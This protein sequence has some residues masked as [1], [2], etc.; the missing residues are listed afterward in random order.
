LKGLPLGKL[1]MCSYSKKALR[2]LQPLIKNTKHS[3]KNF[4]SLFAP[5]DSY[6]IDGSKH[7]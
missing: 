3:I 4:M 6:T 5:P 1:E 2:L 7:S